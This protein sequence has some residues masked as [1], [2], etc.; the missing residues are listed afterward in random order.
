MLITSNN[1][2]SWVNRDSQGKGYAPATS[3][4]ADPQ[5]TPCRERKGKP[6]DAPKPAKSPRS[7]QPIAPTMSSPKQCFPDTV[8][9]A[10]AQ[11]GLAAVRCCKALR[12]PGKAHRGRAKMRKEMT[13]E[14]E[15]ARENHKPNASVRFF[16]QDAY[17]SAIRSSRSKHKPQQNAADS[18]RLKDTR[19][20]SII[21]LDEQLTRDIGDVFA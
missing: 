14:E 4:A 15:R 11:R 7:S 8:P 18:G 19:P 6:K 20:K 13:K 12:K 3:T 5:N 21:I 1:E 10:G 2:E 17:D 16:I 9:Q